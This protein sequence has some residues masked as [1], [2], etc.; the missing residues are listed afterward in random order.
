MPIYTQ[1]LPVF[2]PERQKIIAKKGTNKNFP[3]KKTIIKWF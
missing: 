3:L 2:L 1:A